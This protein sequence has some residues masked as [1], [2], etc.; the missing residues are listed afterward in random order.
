MSGKPPSPVVPVLARDRILEVRGQRVILDADLA[1]LYGTSTKRLNEQVKRN[2]GRFPKDFMF[3]LTSRE[4]G[5]LKSQFATSS[6]G[7]RRSLP[8]AFTEHGAVMAASVLNSPEAIEASVF[9]VRAFIAMRDTLA[10]NRALSMKLA[11]LERRVGGHDETIEALIA[12]I[13]ELMEAPAPKRRRIG[14]GAGE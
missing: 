9:V 8:M 2:A 10:A 4:L 3:R 14:F 6:W 7:G 12:A 11:E 5:N 1:A 13:R